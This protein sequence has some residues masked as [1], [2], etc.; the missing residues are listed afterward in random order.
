MK[1]LFYLALVVF[2]FSCGTDENTEIINESLSNRTSIELLNPQVFLPIENLSSDE[3]FIN[4]LKAEFSKPEVKDANRVSELI[5]REDLNN[6][7]L[8]EISVA[9][10]YTNWFT[11]KNILN[12]KKEIIRELNEDYN[13]ISFAPDTIKKLIENIITLYGYVLVK[14]IFKFALLLPRL[15]L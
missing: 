4:Y 11:Y 6:T 10:G 8:D 14:K 9:M 13:L 12:E 7:E 2:I 3:R 15:Q 1:N 5:N